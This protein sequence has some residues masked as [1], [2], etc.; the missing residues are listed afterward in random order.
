MGAA[1]TSAY[2]RGLRRKTPESTRYP[3]DPRP[4]GAACDMDD[5]SKFNENQYIN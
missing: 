5:I 1:F 3:F 4:L 2:T